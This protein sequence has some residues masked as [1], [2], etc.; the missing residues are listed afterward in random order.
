MG[1]ILNKYPHAQ[2]KQTMPHQITWPVY[3]HTLAYQ[4]KPL[5]EA[6]TPPPVGAQTQQKGASPQGPRTYSAV[7]AVRASSS[8]G[9]VPVSELQ[10]RFLRGG[11][12][13]GAPQ[14]LSS[15]TATLK[16]SL[17]PLPGSIASPENQKETI[18]LQLC[19]RLCKVCMNVV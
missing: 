12:W 11:G 6:A 16:N 10:Q 17:T 3:L 8:L 15:Y 5:H 18:R 19:T 9:T 7:S 4:S 13:E 2:A 1:C 14:L